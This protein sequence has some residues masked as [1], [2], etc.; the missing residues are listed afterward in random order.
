MGDKTIIVEVLTCIITLLG[1]WFAFWQFKNEINKKKT[2]IN[3]DNL[4]EVPL[5]IVTTYDYLMRRSKSKT[6]VGKEEK[7]LLE[8]INDMMANILAYGSVEAIKI[9]STMQQTLYDRVENSNNEKPEK[10]IAYY[11]ILFS[12]VKYDLT[13]VEIS[14]E[15]WYK[16]KI[17][18]YLRSKEKFCEVNNLIVNELALQEF[19]FIR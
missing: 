12:Q 5:K 17:T 9:V 11:A 4:V 13:G 10:V 16:I 7:E 2:N 6:K 18:D 14:P 3:L 1:V 15:E 8:K 19:L